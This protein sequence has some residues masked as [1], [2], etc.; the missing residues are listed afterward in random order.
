MPLVHGLV[1]DLAADR[2]DLELPFALLGL[3]AA[4]VVDEEA[5]HHPGGLAGES[6]PSAEA[7]S[8]DI[9]DST[10]SASVVPQGTTRARGRSD[11]GRVS[12][13]R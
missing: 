10:A 1:S 7:M 2:R 11:S 5:P 4:G 3:V 12:A 13:R 8:D 9:V 6:P